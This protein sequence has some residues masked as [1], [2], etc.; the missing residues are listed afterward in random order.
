MSHK[1]VYVPAVPLSER[2]WKE[3]QRFKKEENLRDDSMA[4]TKLV[5]VTLNE[6]ADINENAG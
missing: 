3:L 2:Q 6:A 4:I 5:Q 1:V